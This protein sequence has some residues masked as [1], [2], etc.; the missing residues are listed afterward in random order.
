M[1]SFISWIGGKKLLRKKIL[2][3]F[4]DPDSFKRYIEVFGGAGWVL[5]ASNKHAAMEVFND[6]NGELINLYRIV[7][8]HPEALQK[9]LEWL[10]LSREQFFDE[11]NRNTRGMTDI[12]RAARFYCLIKES[13]GADCK[14]FGVR[15]RDMQ[16]AVDYLKDVSD[17]LNRVVIENQDFERLIKTY[18]R[19]EALFYLDPPYYEAEK[20]YPDRFNPEDHKRLCECLGGIKGKFV[21]SYNDCPRIRELYEGYTLVEVERADNLVTKSESRKYKELIIKNF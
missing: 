3:Q 13:F 2:E 1:N 15:T 14:S 20:Y 21:L 5:F 19:P 9:E 11:L 4:P 12:Q 17:R 6:A 7:K 18:D 10:L 16:K 8:H